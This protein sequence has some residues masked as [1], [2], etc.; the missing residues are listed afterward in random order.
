MAVYPGSFAH[1]LMFHRLH[2]QGEPA[3]GQGSVSDVA[4]EAMLRSIGTER[5]LAPQEW[6]FRVNAGL[7]Q[8][9]DLCITFDDGLKNQLDVALPVLE[10]LGL[11]AFWFIYSAALHG[12]YDRNEIAN[13]LATRHFPSFE[14]YALQFEALA[15]TAPEAFE[16]A[17]WHSYAQGMRARFPFYSAS[18]LRYRYLRNHLLSLAE[19]EAAVDSLLKLLGLDLHEVAG[20]LWMTTDQVST[21]HASGHV[22]GMHSYSHP[23]S[24][25]ALSAEDQRAEYQ[26]NFDDLT[27]ITGQPP[28]SM[29]H[30]L[31]SYSPATLNI[32]ADLGIE[33]GFCSNMQP[34]HGQVKVNPGPLEFAREDS[35]ALLALAFSG[36]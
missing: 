9:A 24:L 31:N 8:P 30:P 17:D 36:S 11:K 21:L 35:T 32:L 18:D 10:R 15:G 1:G 23:F 22:I 7:L 12:K 26:A 33:C 14:S 4:F 6:M 13:L 19:F 29:S 28:R 2:R 16:S 27:R 5:I 25:S 3:A 34:P 20:Q